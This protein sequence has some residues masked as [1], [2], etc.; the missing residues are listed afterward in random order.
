[1]RLSAAREEAVKPL[2]AAVGTE[3]TPEFEE[4]LF[5][6]AREKIVFGGWRSGKSRLGATE[7]FI[8]WFMKTAEKKPPRL[9]WLVG[10]DYRQT[11]AEFGYLRQ[12]FSLQDGW[13]KSLSM[14]LE[15]PRVLDLI[16]GSRIE[17]KS[18]QYTERLG[19]VA[20]D[21]IICCEAGQVS[22]E[23]R[24]W[25]RGR[26]MEKRGRIIYTG[27]LEDEDAHK[28]W[29][30]YIDLGTEWLEN[31]DGEHTAYS[32]PSW[33]NRSIYSG[34]DDPEIVKF[35]TDL[36]EHTG[37]DFSFK[38][39]IAGIPAGSPYQVYPQL[40]TANLLL[41]APVDMKWIRAAGGIDFGTVH[42]SSQTVGQVNGQNVL[43]VRE[44]VFNKDDTD[45]RWVDVE[46]TRLSKTYNCW[47][48]GTDPNE[49]FMARQFKAEAVSGS[50]GS[51]EARISLVWA[52]LNRGLLMFDKNG[53][54]V[55]ALYDEMSHVHRKRLRSGEIVLDRNNDDRT[56]SLE[57]LVE[58]ID[59][60]KTFDLPKTLGRRVYAPRRAVRQR[61]RV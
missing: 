9:Y 59:G 30:W 17:T 57:N 42:P 53:P 36:L 38:R 11:D 35:R 8:D 37:S 26:V 39:R 32:L 3:L 2:L 29:A 16:D 6:T 52:R 56:A 49:K 51:R 19:S 5:D 44:N 10:P 41:P 4:A 23:T 20:P 47:L 22:E 1:M 27:T 13:I 54:G 25:L 60:S 40:S 61:V 45:A 58:M 43:W 12:W 33:A 28:Q 7:V 31:R 15:G 55:P 50:A 34:E 24:V 21:M 46:K 14:P 18:A 48:W